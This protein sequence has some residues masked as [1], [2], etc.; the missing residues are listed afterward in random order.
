[1]TECNVVIHY[2]IVSDEIYHF[3]LDYGGKIWGA[4]DSWWT[5]YCLNR[6]HKDPEL[7][8]NCVCML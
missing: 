5:V 6:Q 7:Q 4:V 1:M 3:M 8:V 2:Y